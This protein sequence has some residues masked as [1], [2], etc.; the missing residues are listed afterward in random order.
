MR[1]KWVSI[2]LSWQRLSTSFL[3]PINP[4]I[5]H[6]AFDKRSTSLHWKQWGIPQPKRALL[7]NLVAP[8]DS[9]R[10][11]YLPPPQTTS[12]RRGL[13]AWLISEQQ[14]HDYGVAVTSSVSTGASVTGTGQISTSSVI[15]LS[16]AGN[17]LIILQ[18]NRDINLFHKHFLCKLI[19]TVWVELTEKRKWCLNYELQSVDLNVILVSTKAVQLNES[20]HKCR[21]HFFPPRSTYNLSE[22]LLCHKWS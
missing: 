19:K 7:P 12:L 3:Q 8:G 18:M 9:D 11:Q 2:T 13:S 16:L 6:V 1:M 4:P 10:S 14:K 20:Y 21:I 17:D 5:F 15:P 22:G